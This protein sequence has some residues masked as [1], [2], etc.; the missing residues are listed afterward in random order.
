MASIAVARRYARALFRVSSADVS[1]QEG[2]LEIL[3]SI[4]ELFRNDSIRKILVSPVMPKD[5]KI[6]VLEYAA[7]NSDTDPLFKNF[8][9]TVVEAGRVGVFADLAQLFRDLLN[10][11]QGIAEAVVSSVVPLTDSDKTALSERLKKITEKEV[12]LKY[13]IDKDLLGGIFVQMG[14]KVI[15]L[16][17]RS[18]LQKMTQLV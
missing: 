4:A 14:N 13:Q 11:K 5:L 16:S 15:D 12:K 18:R 17:L 8:V 1:K 10:E 7:G 6:N 3:T 2:Y 9:K